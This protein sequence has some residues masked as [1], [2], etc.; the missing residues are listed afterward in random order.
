MS[1]VRTPI[2]GRLSEFDAQQDAL[3]EEYFTLLRFPSVSSE[4][5]HAPDVRACADWLVRFLEDIGL[6]V[7]LWEGHPGPHG[8]GHP[9]IF[10]HWLKAGPDV[11]TV[12]LYNHYDV[13]PVD[14]LPLW[15]SP[16]FEPRRDGTEI[17][18]RG[19][20][21]NK[22]QCFYVLAALRH[23]LRTTGRLPVNVKLCIEGE[24]ETGSS[25]LGGLLAEKRAQLE[26]DY[27]YVVDVGLHDRS[28]PAVTLGVRG[29]A[30]MTVE[31][32]GSSTDLHSG[33]VGGMVYNPN[34]ALTEM[35][36]SCYDENGRVTVAGFYDDV[37]EPAPDERRQLDFAFNP[38]EF[39]AMFGTGANGGERGFEP[40]ER[41]WLRPTLEI[42][43]INGGYSGEGFKTVIPAVAT[44]KLS[45]RLVP[46]QTPDR[47]LQ[48]V[49][50][51]LRSRLPEGMA[52]TVI[53]HGG[54]TAARTP[55]ESEAVRVAASA[56]EELFGKP[57]HYILSGGSI[58]IAAGLAEASGA[59]LVLIG[60][61]LADDNI[62]APNEHFGVDRIRSGFATIIGILERLAG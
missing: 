38:A 60:F 19:A 61:G 27:L 13:Q 3:L 39:R 4:P 32:R 1:S 34:R 41:C 50:D 62:H 33:M 55:I 53:R 22:G 24:E 51:H 48:L 2:H 44:A 29:I 52:L 43:G 9:T 40:L 57:C 54:G 7:E 6:T 30:A 46:N 45:C 18:A 42:N 16:P 10:A 31:L 37:A 11:P 28:I 20:E 17:Y 58:P 8:K 35:L 5:A 26:A 14:P 49:E 25:V 56:L 36:A 47:A 15:L 21:D 23:L 12:L 59:E